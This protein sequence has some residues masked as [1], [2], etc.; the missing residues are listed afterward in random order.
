[1]LWSHKVLHCTLTTVFLA[2]QNGGIVSEF[3]STLFRFKFGFVMYCIKSISEIIVVQQILVMCSCMKLRTRTCTL[4][5]LFH[6]TPWIKLHLL[7][8]CPLLVPF[9]DGIPGA[10]IKYQGK[11]E[12]K[13]ALHELNQRSRNNPKVYSNLKLLFYQTVVYCK[14]LNSI[15]RKKSVLI[16]CYWMFPS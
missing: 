3:P 13:R 2:T 9:R 4:W 16:F 6:L 8:K 10:D 11:K 14:Q 15:F 12:I 7:Q 1:M 5:M